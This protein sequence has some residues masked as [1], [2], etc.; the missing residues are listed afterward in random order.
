MRR[1]RP[2]PAPTP[3]HRHRMT[4]ETSHVT[5]WDTRV[6][7]RPDG[8]RTV[9]PTE[10]ATVIHQRHADTADRH[11]ARTQATLDDLPPD[12]PHRPAV[13]ATVDM[14]RRRAAHHRRMAQAVPAAQLDM[15]GAA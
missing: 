4:P 3:R 15:F 12:D 14:Y 9:T 6:T 10:P 11:A 5:P 8:T 2:P 1:A 7:T 13:A